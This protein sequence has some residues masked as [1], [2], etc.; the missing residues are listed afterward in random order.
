MPKP[1][2]SHPNKL[3]DKQQARFAFNKKKELGQ[4]VSQEF[5]NEWQDFA[6]ALF[7]A[8]QE[9][10]TQLGVVNVIGAVYDVV[11][12]DPDSMI[13]LLKLNGAVAEHLK[14]RVDW[15]GCTLEEF[16]NGYKNM[17]ISHN[18]KPA[19]VAW[20]PDGRVL[21]GEVETVEKQIEK[22]VVKKEVKE[23]VVE[24]KDPAAIKFEKIEKFFRHKEKGLNQMYREGIKQFLEEVKSNLL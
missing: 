11:K 17:L 21:G 6:N 15:Y 8:S 22:E 7:A 24:K 4:T 13:I 3:G 16:Y 19:M 10:T 1:R 5:R 2:P 14:C 20:Q 18:T 9:G 23:V 12:F